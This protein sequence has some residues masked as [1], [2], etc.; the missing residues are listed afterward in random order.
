METPLPE[1]YSPGDSCLDLLGPG[2]AQRLHEDDVGKDKGILKF[3]LLPTTPRH[4]AASMAVKLRLTASEVM[5]YQLADC[6]ASRR[7]QLC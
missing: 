4:S 5:V 6:A 7:Q 1:V 2:D 3:Q